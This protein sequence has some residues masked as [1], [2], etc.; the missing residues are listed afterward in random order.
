MKR[1]IV[2]TSVA[3]RYAKAMLG[4]AIDQR[5]F[6]LVLDQMESFNDQQHQSPMLLVVFLNPAVPQDRKRKI[7]EEIGKKMGFVPLTLKL[8]NTMIENGRIHILDQVIT[9]AEQQFLDRQGILV[10]EVISARKLSAQEEQKLTRKLESFTG[11]KVQVENSIDSAL[12]GGVITKIGTTL[13]DGTV[14]SQLEHLKAK[15]VQDK[16]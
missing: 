12:I 4:A 9:S 5:N 10:A 11:K 13:Y 1:D 6:S 3:R 2:I 15:I 14:V 7:L 16:F 8:L